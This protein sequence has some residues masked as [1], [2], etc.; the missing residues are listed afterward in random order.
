MIRDSPARASAFAGVFFMWKEFSI[1]Y[2]Y[3]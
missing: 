2:K 3:I 1:Y